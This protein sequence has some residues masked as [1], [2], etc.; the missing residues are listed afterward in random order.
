MQCLEACVTLNDRTNHWSTVLFESS[1]SQVCVNIMCPSEKSRT[2]VVCY[3][4]LCFLL[5]QCKLTSGICVTS[6]LHEFLLFLFL[7]LC[8][9]CLCVSVCVS[10]SLCVS[11][12]VCL[13]LSACLPACL[14]VC[15]FVC[16]SLSIIVG[17]LWRSALKTIELPTSKGRQIH[18]SWPFLFYRAKD[19]CA[20]NFKPTATAHLQ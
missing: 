9:L 18:P 12:S 16:L 13:S 15:L 3:K 11:V 6:S 7:L 8:A 10:V 1:V 20:W 2:S 19:E 5:Q 4:L 14:P 17:V